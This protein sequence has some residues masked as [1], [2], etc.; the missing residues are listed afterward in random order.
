MGIRCSL[1]EYKLENRTYSPEEWQEIQKRT[2]EKFEFV[3]TLADMVHLARLAVALPIAESYKDVELID[4]ENLL[5][6]VSA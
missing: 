5:E 4:E 2:G 1:T 3:H 6:L